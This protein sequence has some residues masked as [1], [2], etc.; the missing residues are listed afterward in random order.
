MI[1]KILIRFPNWVGD[2]VMATPV[3][4]TLHKAYSEAEIYALVRPYAQDVLKGNPWITKIIPCNDHSLKGW[5]ELRHI[6]KNIKPDLAIVLT[7]SFQSVLS[8]RL[9]GV[10]NIYGY[11]RDGRSLFLTGGP[12][13]KRGE[14]KYIPIPMVDYYLEICRFLSIPI[15]ETIKPTLFMT[16]E[17]KEKGDLFLQQNGIN[18]NDLVIGINPGAKFGASKCWLPEYF[19]QLAELLYQKY[20]T[21][22]LLLFTGPGEESLANYIQEH[23][24][25]PL[26]STINKNT[27]LDI[28]KRLVQRCNLLVT[29]DTGTRHYAVALDVPLVVMFG[30]TDQRYTNN[31]LE[32]TIILDQHVDCAPCHLKKC[33][34]DQK[35]MKLITPNMVFDACIQQIN[36]F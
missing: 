15:P 35:C 24:N 8:L 29:N 26:I 36:A 10:K 34:T 19:A 23:S 5:K 2:V 7:N 14:K 25:A 22:K 4:E 28:L 12:K 9:A 16:E 1:N 21:S 20:P 27:N 11:K 3:L 17:A 13:P 31:N 18:P 6:L 32:K 33:P 30:P